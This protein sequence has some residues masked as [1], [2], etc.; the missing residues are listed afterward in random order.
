MWGQSWEASGSR[1]PETE[2]RRRDWETQ[3]GAGTEWKSLA[4]RQRVQRRP[5]VPAAPE[6]A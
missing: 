2:V 6:T 1:S 4:T 5:R 3:G